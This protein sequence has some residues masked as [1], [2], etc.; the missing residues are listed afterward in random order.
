MRTQT[1]RFLSSNPLKAIMLSASMVSALCS[2]AAMAQTDG[3]Q[4]QPS[5]AASK[6]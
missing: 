3:L 6:G 5:G 2:G 4:V 1:S